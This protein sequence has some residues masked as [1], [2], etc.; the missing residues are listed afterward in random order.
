MNECSFIV[1]GDCIVKNPDKRAEIMQVA[2]QLLTEHGFDRV[3]VSMIA[4]KANVAVGTIYI[5]FASKDILITE[6]FSELESNISSELKKNKLTDKSIRDKFLYLTRTIV[7]YFISHPLHF[8]YMEQYIN[9][10][11]GVSLRRDKL[12]GK[13]DANDIFLETFKEGINGKILKDLPLEVL[14]SLSIA[15]VI[16]SL[17][18]HVLGFITLD[19]T[20]I[21]KL[22][23]ACWD[24]IKR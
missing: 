21:D 10:P 16:F 23:E 4:E 11:F 18:D 13:M 9:S 8:G 3:P 14:F 5:Y 2:L 1:S 17:R 22:A 24:G 19:T 7:E 15:P 12:S 20:L 6:I